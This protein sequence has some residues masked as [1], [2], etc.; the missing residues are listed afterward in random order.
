VRVIDWSALMAEASPGP[1]ALTAL[2]QRLIAGGELRSGDRLPSERDLAE[3]LGA[4][5]ALVREAIHEL[6]LKGIVDRRPGRGTR[7]TEP[8]NAG[9]LLGALSESRRGLLEMQ[10]L[11]AALEPS[12]AARAADRATPADLLNLE[13]VIE[14]SRGALTPARSAELDERFHAAVARATQNPLLTAVVETT[15]EWIADVRRES[16]RTAAGRR[17]S[18]TGHQKILAAV[19]AHDSA[20]AAAAMSDHLDMVSALVGTHERDTSG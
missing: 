14:E 20:A 19:R 6:E 16:H 3:M 5:R 17:H 10:D 13:R 12:I 8:Q 4:S 1:E 11:R 9:R 2:V 7:I 15:A 18:L